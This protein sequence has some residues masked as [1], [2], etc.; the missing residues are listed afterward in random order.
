MIISWIFLAILIALSAFFSSAETAM[1]TVNKIKVRTLADNGDKRARTLQKVHE[2]WPKMLSA[3]LIGNNIVNIAASALATTIAMRININVGVMTM[4][5][6][7]VVLI[8]GEITP[9]NAAT[10]YSEKVALNY[11][12]VILMLIRLLTPLIWIINIISR[13][14]TWLLR[15]DLENGGE[16]MTEGELRTI[17]DVSHEDGVIESEEKQMINNV[18]DFGDSLARDIMIPRI[19]VA[20]IDVNAL[21]EDIKE[22]FIRER[23]TRL[24][25]YKDDTD[26]IIGIVNMKDLLLI[27]DHRSFKIQDIMREAYFTYETKKTSDLMMEMRRESATMAIVLSEY[28]AAVGIVTMEDLLEEIVGEIRDEYDD[29]EEELI[30]LVNDREYIVAGNVK[31]DDLND[32]I[33]ISLQSEDYDSV[34]GY[35]IGMLDRLPKAGES[36]VTDDNIKLEVISVTKNRIERVHIYLPEK[37]EADEDTDEKYEQVT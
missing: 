25:V 13:F 1:T 22:I 15:L 4:I 11:A 20:E 21:Y 29:D 2:Q 37:R 5:L 33:G 6:T 8:F 24:P 30:R 35:I 3:I 27:E 7:L 14:I 18:F 36:V 19:D 17:V 34:G 28:G 16:S 26:N 23:Y 9:K 10:V 32:A 31:L 12:S